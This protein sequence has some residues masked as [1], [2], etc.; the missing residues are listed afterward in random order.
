MIL[1]VGIG[2]L[3]A[4]VPV[5]ACD[6]LFRKHIVRSI[7]LRDKFN[8]EIF[9]REDGI[10]RILMD[11]LTSEK[12][13]P[14]SPKVKKNKICKDDFFNKLKIPSDNDTEE[15]YNDYHLYKIEVE[16]DLL[17]DKQRSVPVYEI[18][19]ITLYLPQEINYRGILEPL[20]SFKYEDCL[21]VF[22]EDKR[23]VWDLN[24]GKPLNFKEVFLL[25]HYQSTIVKIGDENELYFDQIYPDGLNAFL[26]AKEAENKIVE[27]FYRLYNPQ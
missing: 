17:F 22:K 23:A 16:E 1:L 10:I 24:D 9:R 18:K 20:A 11:A 2:K 26:A 3:T 7:D 5:R 19:Y 12:I 25:H 14:Y 6:V 27:Y 21:K 15:A 8:S 4:Q 13:T